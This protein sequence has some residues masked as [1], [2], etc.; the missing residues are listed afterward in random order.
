MGKRLSLLLALAVT[1]L[2]A[3]AAELPSA[4]KVGKD[5]SLSIGPA[6]LLLQVYN[7]KWS[8]GSWK[9]DGSAIGR[10]GGEAAGEF[11]LAG[12][13]VKVTESVKPLT[14][15]SF[16]FTADAVFP[17]P[18][19]IA[20]FC[21]SL[22]L[23]TGSGP[24]NVTVD[25]KK[26]ALPEKFTDKPIAGVNS[27]RSLEAVLPGGIAIRVE[28][29]FRVAVQDN[30]K[31]KRE[32]MALRLYGTPGSGTVEK[33]SID[34]T[35]TVGSIIS[36]PVD[37]SKSA[38]FGFADEKANDGKGGWSDQGAENDLRAFNQRKVKIE[39]VE[40]DIVDP[41]ANN[42]KAAIVMGRTVDKTPISVSLP[43][44]SKAR[45]I[46]LLHASA[47]TPSSQQP[48][49]H[50]NVTFADGS[51]QKIPVSLQDDSGN[52][53]SPMPR[54]NAA[55]A[56]KHE[57][58]SA[59]IGLYAAPFELKRDDPRMIEFE[60]NTSPE[61]SEA[62][63]MIA[64][65]SLVNRP[66]QF[67]YHDQDVQV[68]ANGQWRPLEFT[69]EIVEGSPLDFSR[70]VEAPA[71]KYGSIIARPDGTLAFEKAP[72]KRVRLF[73]ANLCFTASYLEKAEADRLART[74]RMLG[75]NTVRIHHHDTELLDPK[76]NDSLTFDPVK[77]DKLDYL[78]YA[79]GQQGLYV[80][81]DLYTNRIFRPGDNI[82]ECKTYKERQMKA[83][84]PVSQA[85]MD[86]WKAFSRKLL[87]HRNAYTG[88]L[89]KEDPLIYSYNLINEETLSSNWRSVQMSGVYQEK[90]DRWAKEKGY[91]KNDRRFRQF[92]NEL[93]DKVLEEQ[94]R[95]LRDDIK[96]KPL[97]TSLNY[98]HQTNLVQLRHRF[99]LV[100]NHNY[101][102]HPSFPQARW[103]MP[104]AYHQRS[105]TGQKASLPRNMMPTRIF[106]K[107]FMVTE[108]NYV[109]P[110]IYRA[111]GGPLI[112][113]YPA[114]QDWDALYRFA[115]SHSHSS[116]V[117][118]GA[119]G[120]FDAAND[121]LAQLS[122]RISVLLFRRGDVE[123]A[124]EKY[125]YVVPANLFDTEEP[126]AF[127]PAFTE[128]GLIAQ[129]GSVYADTPVPAGVTRLSYAESTDPAALKDKKIA[130]LWENSLK[131]NVADS[132]TGQLSLNAPAK[133]LA[134]KTP[135]SETLTLPGGN[136]SGS[137]MAVRDAAAFQTVAALSL[138]DLPLAESKSVLLLQLTNI[139][140]TGAVFGT[141]DFTLHRSGGRLPI[142]LEHGTATVEINSAT[143]FKVTALKTDGSP[144]GEIKGELKD[145]KF[146]FR[147]DTASFPCGV[148]A[149]H[150]T[151]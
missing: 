13:S 25:G 46:V 100:D 146:I 135:R 67:T 151:R 5:G 79:M 99:D 138:D 87:E 89:W 95:Y 34:L 9:M 66:M 56:W 132:A 8:P 38:N 119:P 94:L 20:L 57:N 44:D 60:L 88:K 30:R 109:N 16:R 14:A 17:E 24:F 114:L 113:A 3:G 49:G 10:Q 93:Q 82:P 22:Q 68:V 142:L 108:F 112:G 145:G 144:A 41:A 111:E 150:L 126:L 127:P 129:I 84:I 104:K 55:V 136:L 1:W 139:N 115:W 2:T 28:G 64:G 4:V 134:V 23:P 51:V 35:V 39:N 43:R 74:F 76:A 40:F 83:L 54:K 65:V 29:N 33:S 70:Y 116:V 97:L 6:N 122:D 141:P 19:K 149:M 71:G 45:G 27:A 120:G 37:I 26:L 61:H 148:M 125:A 7:E 98:Q 105:A 143:A 118:L 69:K 58:K 90:Y 85:A 81:T 62:M 36:T 106:D 50:L 72:D 52:W 131:K 75:Y 12:K 86:N 42:G 140:N 123:A 63:W 11:I 32:T 133:T 96:V 130:G 77:V 47:W 117:N 121:P 107:P 103:Q 92:L 31:F 110:N 53:W 124:K 73:G 102:D 18:T 137:W 15:D 128:L 101:H 147:A 80:T 48:L 91:E 21:A 78:V 59:A